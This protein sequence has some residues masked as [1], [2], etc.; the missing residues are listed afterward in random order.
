MKTPKILSKSNKEFDLQFSKINSELSFSF[1]HFNHKKK[2]IS[3]VS[4]K[5]NLLTSQIN[6]REDKLKQDYQILS[7]IDKKLK[8]E[9]VNFLKSISSQENQLS[10]QING[11]FQI[12]EKLENQIKSNQIKIDEISRIIFKSIESFKINKNI[13]HEHTISKKKLSKSLNELLKSDYLDQIDL[14]T[15]NIQSINQKLTKINII[16][17]KNKKK[18]SQYENHFQKI[19]LEKQKL[20]RYL[21]VLLSKKVKIFNSHQFFLH[22][23]SSYNEFDSNFDCSNQQIYQ[24]TSFQTKITEITSLLKNKKLIYNDYKLKLENLNSKI[25][26]NKKEIFDL[27]HQTHIIKEKINHFS[28][29]NQK[30]S[31][32]NVQS[33]INFKEE[34][35]SQKL[36]ISKINFM[37]LKEKENLE[38][39]KNQINDILINITDYFLIKEKLYKE[40]DF[41]FLNLK[42]LSELTNFKTVEEFIQINEKLFLPDI[43]YKILD[44]E[45]KNCYNII[46]FQK[47]EIFY[48]NYLLKC[49]SLNFFN[50]FFKFISSELT[51]IKND[52]KIENLMKW[53][54]FLF[55]F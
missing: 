10:N 4:S 35:E 40:K 22:N 34:I 24:Q 51:L 33:F 49:F 17:E 21:E 9:K 28:L 45:L 36:Q 44:D 53:K 19:F 41:E 46:Q 50:L 25:N 39:K 54:S 23:S 30:N 3:E 42:K 18:I 52:Y 26:S 16:F 29:I 48:W 43:T 55:S 12:L 27:L 31:H 20:E 38:K 15:K 37:N 6:A 32:F 7:D 14:Y 1:D 47:D 2:Q 5:Y 11:S 8:L 13:Y